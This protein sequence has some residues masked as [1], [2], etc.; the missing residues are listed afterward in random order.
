MQYIQ[1][2]CPINAFGLIT[3]DTNNDSYY[4]Y[5]N[6]NPNTCNFN[7]N[8]GAYGSEFYT[9]YGIV[10][11]N[12]DNAITAD[13]EVKV[14]C[15]FDWFNSNEWEINATNN[16]QEHGTVCYDRNIIQTE[17]INVLK[18]NPNYTILTKPHSN[19]ISCDNSNCVMYISHQL[20]TWKSGININCPN[21]KYTCSVVWYVSIYI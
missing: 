9:P 5:D 19:T 1:V 3:N 18:D 7:L 16:Y 20:N 21:D 11:I 4:S 15:E 13:S 14:Y 6:I 17:Y 12:T 8:W 10:A 2:N